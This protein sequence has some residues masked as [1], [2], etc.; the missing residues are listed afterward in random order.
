MLKIMSSGAFCFNTRMKKQTIRFLRWTMQILGTISPKKIKLFWCRCSIL[1]CWHRLRCFSIEREEEKES[2]LVED[3]KYQEVSF[4]VK[5]WIHVIMEGLAVVALVAFT[6]GAGHCESDK[7]LALV[8]NGRSKRRILLKR[9]S[10]FHL[11]K[12]IHVDVVL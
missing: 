7:S 6:F 2:L 3:F 5:T 12:L 9:K 1:H 4:A 11:L 10:C 8:R